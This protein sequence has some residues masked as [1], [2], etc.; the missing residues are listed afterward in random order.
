MTLDELSLKIDEH[1]KKINA[2]TNKIKAIDKRIKLLKG[3][4]AVDLGDIDYGPVEGYGMENWRN[5]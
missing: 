1:V 3:W 5:D 4:V 2:S